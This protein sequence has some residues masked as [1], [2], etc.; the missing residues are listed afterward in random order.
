[1]LG[2]APE[3]VI[4]TRFD[5]LLERGDVGRVLRLLEHGPA[6]A[7]GAVQA[8]ECTLRHRD[9]ST[10]QFEILHTNLLEDEHV[11][12]IVL[13]GRDVSERKA[14]EQQLSHQ[15][16]HDPVTGLANRA[17]FVERVRHAVARSRRDG[18]GLAVVFLDLDDFKTINDSLGHAAGDQVLLEVAKRLN[19]EIRASDTAAR[20][21]GDEF[22]L[23]LEGIDSAAEATDTAERILGSLLTPLGV[24]HKELEI[25]SSLGIAMQDGGTP[26]DADELIR[27]ADAAMYIAKREGKG[28]FRLFEP[29]M[30]AGVLERLELRAELQRAITTGQ[31]ELHYQPVVRLGDGTVAGVEALVRWRHP[32]RGLIAPD[33]FIPLA[34]E[35]G[36]IVP[37]GRWVLREGCRQALEFQRQLEHDPPL[38]MSINLSVKQLER[39]DVVGDVRDALEACG[40]APG[41]LTLEM[42]ESV[43][44][45]DT[46]GVIGRLEELRAL[47]VN[48]AMDDFGT[49]Y[50]SLSYLS[51]LPVDTLKMDRSFLRAGASPHAAGLAT[52]VVALGRTLGLEI[53]TEGIEHAEQWRAMR[54]LGCQL[55]QGYFFGAPMDAD[56]ALEHL[57]LR[58]A[59]AAAPVPMEQHAP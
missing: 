12:G 43:M 50:S 32:E 56:T 4:G 21:G 46:D 41:C 5:R 2:H 44:M 34:E 27:N 53:V 49:G 40:L 42:T 22:A 26:V 10:R 37:I 57:R 18:S 17:L 23:L 59:E 48:L 33:T 29:E 15:A 28:A 39:S 6:D 16:F 19:E 51:R 35:M 13:N 55:G 38:R 8:L 14:F 7:D 3:D 54:D 52:A 20:F 30:H 1:V 24:E 31:L 36:L 47:G 58:H 9:G 45:T 25:R 11:R